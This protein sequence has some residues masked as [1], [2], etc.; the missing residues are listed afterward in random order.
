MGSRVRCRSALPQ[1]FAFRS[2]ALNVSVSYRLRAVIERPGLLKSNVAATQNVEFYPIDP[3]I[4]G[5]QD[6]LERPGI[7]DDE[8]AVALSINDGWSTNETKILRQHCSSGLL[9]IALPESRIIR[10]GDFLYLGVA[11][12]IPA[13]LQW[14]SQIIWLCNLTIRL[15]T[16]TT[17]TVGHH[18]QTGV[19]FV[20]I[21]TISGLL[22]LKISEVDTQI[23]LPS[24]LWQHCIYTPAIPSFQL[25]GV[26]RSYQLTVIVNFAS[27]YMD[28]IS[29]R[30]PQHTI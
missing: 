4:R 17:A 21:C 9:Q 18:E 24:A 5:L 29:V 22:P 20:D 30:Y 2:D 14:I 23:E 15:K 28:S 3:P 27:P 1:C 13:E 7:P 25:C 6:Q 12:S 26:V 8:G 11:L 19:D 16:M 10:P